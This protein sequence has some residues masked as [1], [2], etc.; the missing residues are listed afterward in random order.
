M[1]DRCKVN[2]LGI[3]EAEREG[4][5][6]RRFAR[7]TRFGQG[8][9]VRL[10]HQPKLQTP[11]R[12]LTWTKMGSFC[13]CL[14]ALG[15]LGC[16][17]SSAQCRGSQAVADVE[18][19]PSAVVAF[20]G[21]DAFG[22]VPVVTPDAAQEDA[23]PSPAPDAAQ[24]ASAWLDA[25]IETDAAGLPHL[26]VLKVHPS[27][28]SLSL[29]TASVGEGGALLFSQGGALREVSP[30]KLW[31]RTDASPSRWEIPLAA[32]WEGAS[33]QGLLALEVEIEL[34]DQ[35][36]EG[37]PSTNP[38]PSRDADSPLLHRQL[39]NAASFQIS[40]SAEGSAIYCQVAQ[41]AHHD[42][43][44]PQAEKKPFAIEVMDAQGRTL[45]R[46]LASADGLLKLTHPQFEQADAD[47]QPLFVVA[48]RGRERAFA[49]VSLPSADN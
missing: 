2:R 14:A 15:L 23:P 17:G 39:L 35:A 8:K 4:A 28:E 47:S 9:T 21:D 19:E 12:L 43:T 5:R 48:R 29:N 1:S 27:V 37:S 38:L 20:Q 31:T 30:Q 7:A 22:L 33:V 42:N 45:A 44:D 34:Q 16:L 3:C 49:P 26:L 11:S 41:P 6:Q 36:P 24:L 13:V 25:V 18:L 40:A 10:N 32:L 46:G